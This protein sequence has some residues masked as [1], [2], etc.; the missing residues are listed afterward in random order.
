MQ[1][2]L[3]VFAK[4]FPEAVLIV[5]TKTGELLQG[6]GDR[7]VE[8]LARY[9]STAKCHY[10]LIIT[11]TKTYVLRDDFR[12]TGPES[13]HITHTFSTVDLLNGRLGSAEPAAIATERELA[14]L[15]QEWLERLT[16]SYEEALPADPEVTEAFFP[17]IV[18]AVAGGRV[19]AEAAV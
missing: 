4:D 10:G 9:M 2:D 5:E 15:A 3:A 12:S 6:D 16:T 8:Q 14:F 19:V 7:T 13:I 18:G 1:V 17:D 11:P